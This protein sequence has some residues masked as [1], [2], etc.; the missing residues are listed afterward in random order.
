MLFQLKCVEWI[1]VRSSNVYTNI[2]FQYIV[3]NGLTVCFKITRN[4]AIRIFNRN[5]I[6]TSLIEIS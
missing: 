5:F 2:T 4:L 6:G 1:V 3:S